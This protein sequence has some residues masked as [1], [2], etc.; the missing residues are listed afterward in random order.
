MPVAEEAGRMTPTTAQR[1]G[2]EIIKVFGLKQ[3][4]TGRVDLYEGY[5][6]KTPVGVARVVKRLVDEAEETD[7]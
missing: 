4:S 5:G 3:K 7:G 2:D 6:D 1:L